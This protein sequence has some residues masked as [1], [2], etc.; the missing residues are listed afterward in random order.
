MA[1]INVV[2]SDDPALARTVLD[3]A[4]RSGT[5]VNVWDMLPAGVS[6]DSVTDWL[7]YFDAASASLA[8]DGS[9]PAGGTVYVPSMRTPYLISDTL[10]VPGKVVLQ[11]AGRSAS[12]IKAA[13]GFTTSNPLIELGDGGANPAFGTRVENL[14]LDCDN[15]VEVC[16]FSSQINEQSGVFNCIVHNFTDI[17]IDFDRTGGGYVQIPSGVEFCEVYPT[18]NGGWSY[19]IRCKGFNDARINQVTINSG[20]AASIG[21]AGVFIDTCTPFSIDK[22]HA[23]RCDDA[24]FV[25]GATSFG[26]IT[27][28]TA[29]TDVGDNGVY[30]NTGTKGRFTV[31]DLYAPNATNVLNDVP[32]ST[33]MTQASVAG[34][35][36]FY[37][38]ERGAGSQESAPVLTTAP[39][40]TT[41][42]Y[43]PL[44]MHESAIIN[45]R[46][47]QSAGAG[48]VTLDLSKGSFQDVTLT[49]DI[50]LTHSNAVDGQMFTL[51]IAQDA[52]GGHT[53]YFVASKFRLNFGGGSPSSTAAA[54]LCDYFQFITLGDRAHMIA[55]PALGVPV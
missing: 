19:G 33:V 2:T 5:S 47:N 25:T 38:I 22:L 4:D 44:V 14:H 41:R 8:P 29:T 9:D 7:P 11:G 32:A 52:T 28:V 34:Y 12:R 39:G 27:N 40:A 51:R 35:V 24:V 1:T 49:G 31:Q 50:S 17:G 30:L 43:G 55:E 15:R 20:T 53:L 37:C 45:T 10:N 13:A 23:E 6:P 21:S 54:N 18:A 26:T 48:T 42:M 3:A 36:G 16:V 46:N